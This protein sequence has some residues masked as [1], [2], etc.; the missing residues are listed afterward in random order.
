MKDN[1]NQKNDIKDKDIL[2]KAGYLQMFLA[3]FKLGLFTIGGGLAMIPIL[4]Q[5]AV[6]EYHWMAEEEMVDCIAV[7]QSLPGVVAI[8]M[9]T[10]VG[11][12]KRG[13]LGAICATLG[14]VAPSLLIIILIAAFVGRI[15]EI[16]YV[17]GAL[18][19]IRAAA[20]GLIAWAT[21][22]MGKTVLL[23]KGIF[24]WILAVSSFVLITFA[25]VSAVWAILG[26][27]VLGIGYAKLIAK[28]GE[29]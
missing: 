12:K 3:F 26:G 18:A 13:A 2:E 4:Q 9:A 16:S 22:K 1:I 14:V 11:M 20:V 27:I 8:N 5:K 15:D 21:W 19:G 28:G 29:N 23:G 6:E 10:Y 7:S 24:A 25:G 17:Q